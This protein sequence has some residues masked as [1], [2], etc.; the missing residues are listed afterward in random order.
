MN[1]STE[2]KASAS[3]QG[4]SVRRSLQNLRQEMDDLL[5]RFFH[6]EDGWFTGRVIPAADVSE[7]GE[8]IEVTMDLPGID[9]D[10]LDLEVRGQALMIR[11]ERKLPRDDE[12]RIQHRTERRDGE[13]ARM[14]EL[15]CD[16][17]EDEVVAEYSHG[18]LTVTLPKCEEARR[19]KIYVRHE[20]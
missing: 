10:Q 8:S 2:T 9:P 7:N 12:S 18:V 4:P 15:P 20:C 16:V 3:S 13:F 5:S 11:G 1:T 17:V 19:H 14:I 6:V